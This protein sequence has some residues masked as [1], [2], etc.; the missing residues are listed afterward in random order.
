M[1]LTFDGCLPGN[2][3]IFHITGYTFIQCSVTPSSVVKLAA[4]YQNC[5][6]SAVLRKLYQSPVMIQ[7]FWV[8]WSN[9][10]S[11]GREIL[12]VFKFEETTPCDILK[13]KVHCWWCHDDDVNQ[14]LGIMY[15]P[16]GHTNWS[17]MSS[18]VCLSR[19][20]IT[21]KSG[22]HYFSWSSYNRKHLSCILI[23]MAMLLASRRLTVLS[24]WPYCYFLISE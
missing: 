9:S 12:R 17:W 15:N 8:V 7:C 6:E 11:S 18:Q 10:C 22:Q 21:H 19:L 3:L 23:V 14:F 24:L 1:H 13:L 16:S 2:G 20:H 5:W 4:L